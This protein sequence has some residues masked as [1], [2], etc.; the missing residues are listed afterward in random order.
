MSHPVPSMF[1]GVFGIFGTL[2]MAAAVSVP[3]LVKTVT[4][5]T[6]AFTV[7]PATDIATTHA[8]KTMSIF[9]VLTILSLN[10]LCSSLPGH[11]CQ[12]L[13]N[14]SPANILGKM[15]ILKFDITRSKLRCCP[16][17]PERDKGHIQ[18]VESGSHTSLSIISLS[19]RPS[20]YLSLQNFLGSK[21]SDS[22][23]PRTN[24]SSETEQCLHIS[25]RV[26]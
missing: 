8:A 13:T 21:F 16:E 2:L 19:L 6:G 23:I 5:K 12:D 15:N 9:A 18:P 24:L 11:S 22:D 10:I 7:K 3:R 17:I 25:P 14:V 1:P 20:E 4:Q 26:F